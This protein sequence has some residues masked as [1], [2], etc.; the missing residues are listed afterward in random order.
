MPVCHLCTSVAVPPGPCPRIHAPHLLPNSPIPLAPTSPTYYSTTVTTTTF[1][2]PQTSSPRLEKPADMYEQG[3][4][5][6]HHNLG[7]GV[8]PVIGAGFSK[9]VVRTTPGG[10]RLGAVGRQGGGVG[11]FR[12]PGG[13]RF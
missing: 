5:G 1:L 9:Q 11:H 3:V 12:T 13:G 4:E 10:G 7:R 6:E 2:G 8:P